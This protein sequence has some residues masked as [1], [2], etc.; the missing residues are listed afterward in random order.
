[1]YTWYI[2]GNANFHFY[3]GC[4]GKKNSSSFV[5]VLSIQQFTAPEKQKAR[6]NEDPC[7]AVCK[8]IP[9]FLNDTSPV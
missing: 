2:V 4:C 6:S 9:V 1:M 7:T 8:L 5:F 3:T